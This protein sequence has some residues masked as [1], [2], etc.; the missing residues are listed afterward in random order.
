MQRHDV[1]S[2][3]MRR[4]CIDVDATL[5]KC[6][7]LAWTQSTAEKIARFC[8]EE[9][10]VQFYFL[11]SFAL[12]SSF[13]FVSKLSPIGRMQPCS[14]QRYHTKRPN[15]TQTLIFYA[16]AIWRMVERHIV[17]LLFV[18]PSVRP[19]ASGVSNL[20]LSL[21]KRRH[22]CPLVTFLVLLLCVKCFQVNFYRFHLT[23][24]SRLFT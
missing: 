11:S 7:V 9:N 4:R 17:F 18:R 14:L 21:F 8:N 2:T 19:S 10:I 22:P 12:L 1:T 13:W 5:Y 24:P 20:R 3:S 23:S 15:E 16:L 6:F